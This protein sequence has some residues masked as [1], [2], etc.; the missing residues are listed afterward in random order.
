MPALFACKYSNIQ[1]IFNLQRNN[2]VLHEYDDCGALNADAKATRVGRSQ[3]N[4]VEQTGHIVNKKRSGAFFVL[5]SPLPIPFASSPTH[6]SAKLGDTESLFSLNDAL[7]FKK[8]NK[9]TPFR[10]FWAIISPPSSLSTYRHS[11]SSTL[12]NGQCFHFYSKAN[13]LSIVR[14][15]YR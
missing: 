7:L 9:F 1:K 12:N 13:S 14:C 11:F 10:P 5:C 3:L 4:C 6:F 2:Y 15:C 8:K